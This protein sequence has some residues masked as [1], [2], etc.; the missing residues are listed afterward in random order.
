VDWASIAQNA[1]I[2]GLAFVLALAFLYGIIAVAVAALV[3]IW[4]TI[5]S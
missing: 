5:T 1:F 3:G 4:R 2:Q